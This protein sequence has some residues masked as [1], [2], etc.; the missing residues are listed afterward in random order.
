MHSVPIQVFHSAPGEPETFTL[1]S[2]HIS[3]KAAE[4]CF[5][6]CIREWPGHRVIVLDWRTG[7]RKQCDGKGHVDG[8]FRGPTTMRV[9]WVDREKKG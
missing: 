1:W 8:P 7:E 2:W 4:R 6:E 3:G 5:R 9:T